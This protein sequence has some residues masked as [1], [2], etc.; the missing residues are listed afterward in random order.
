MAYNRRLLTQ[1]EEIVVEMRPNWAFLGWPLVAA[2]AAA[3][4]AVVVQVLLPSNPPKWEEVLGWISLGPLVV[5]VLWLA[6][7]LLRWFTTSL[8]LTTTRVIQRSG[9][10]SRTGHEI[11]LERINELSYHQ[12]I[13]GRLAGYGDVL[14]ETGG[15]TGLETFH[16]IRRPA[17]VQSLITQQLDTFRR[18][19]MGMGSG[20]YGP[21]GPP[22]AAYVP[23]A[24]PATPPGGTPAAGGPGSAAD[25]LVQ[26]DELRKR[27]ILSD[28]EYEAKKA[29]LLGQL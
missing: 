25:R 4:L 19:S 2:V 28:E 22:P 3:A 1:G 9:V 12:S 20:G 29:E 21:G 17:A 23:P 10:F 8:V 5:A 16:Y 13:F 27:G 7:R 15:E 14:V 11:R 24:S 6:G 18:Q 26:L